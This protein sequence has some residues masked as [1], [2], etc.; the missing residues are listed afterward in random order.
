MKPARTAALLAALA[1]LV[2]S[3]LL[4]DELHRH[5]D[6][7]ERQAAIPARPDFGRPK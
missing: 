2:A 3:V 7:D 5:L 6:E 4:V 1:V